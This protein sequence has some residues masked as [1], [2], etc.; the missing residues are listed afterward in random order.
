MRPLGLSLILSLVFVIVFARPAGAQSEL[1]APA[2]QYSSEKAKRLATHHEAALRELS[3]NVYHCLPWL[4]IQRG[5]IGFFK[6]KHASVDDRYLSL[7]AF[8]EQESSASFT[9]LSPEQRAAAM[10]SRYV[11][12]LMRRMSV[13]RALMVDPDLAGLTVIVEW[14]KP[15]ASINGRRVHETIAVFVDKPVAVGYLS[16]RMSMAELAQRARVYAYDGETALGEVKLATWDDDFA[17]TYQVQNYR[18]PV[19]LDCRVKG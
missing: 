1:V 18:M 2:D 6:P 4:E 3:Q 16:G 11:G 10:F 13:S 12:H 17:S 8:V 7:R 5:S 19:G 9:R 15:A 14:V